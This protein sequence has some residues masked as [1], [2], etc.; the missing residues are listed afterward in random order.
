MKLMIEDFPLWVKRV[1]KGIEAIKAARKKD[2]EK[3]EARWLKGP[4]GMLWWKKPREGKPPRNRESWSPSCW[5]PSQRA[6]GS[7]DTLLTIKTA[8]N[9]GGIKEIMLTDEELEVILNWCK[10]EK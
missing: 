6:W 10:E 5:Y 8:L 2:D 7:L 9:T 4:T 1:E 3:Y